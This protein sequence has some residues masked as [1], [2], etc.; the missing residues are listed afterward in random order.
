MIFKNT[1]RP[2]EAWQFLKWWLSTET[3]VK[4]AYLMQGTYGAEYRWN[5]ANLD[6]FSQMSYTEE[7]K[8]VIM[9]S[10]KEQ[11]EITYHPANY[12]IE[13]Q[14]SDIWNSVVVDFENMV[15]EID[16]ATIVTNR[17]LIRKLAEFGFCDEEGN[18]IKN[19]SMYA[20][21]DLQ[22]KLAEIQAK[23]GAAK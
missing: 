14:T 20:Y 3:Q 5:T 12:M 11:C 2:D 10:W 16:R 13:R 9:D 1:T 21:S 17:E 15:E 8:K 23:E 7:D 4:Y 6:A 19:Y 22:K 18:M